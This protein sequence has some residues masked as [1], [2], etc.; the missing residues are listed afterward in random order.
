MDTALA[1]GFLGFM[2]GL[3]ALLFLAAG[4]VHL[5]RDWAEDRRREER[6]AAEWVRQHRARQDQDRYTTADERRPE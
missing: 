6:L 3:L 5:A 1:A 2:L 4:L